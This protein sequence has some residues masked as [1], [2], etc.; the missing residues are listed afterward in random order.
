VLYDAGNTERVTFSVMLTGSARGLH[1]LDV[2]RLRRTV[3]PLLERRSDH[4]PDN[5]PGWLRAACDAMT[6]E[7][8]LRAGAAATARTGLR[9]PR[10]PR[11][12]HGDAL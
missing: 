2:I 10:S 7:P 3:L 12:E 6:G 5:R 11:A 1:P 9:E 8:N 4:R